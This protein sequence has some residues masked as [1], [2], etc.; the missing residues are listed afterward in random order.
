MAELPKL[1][2]M[3]EV[4]TMFGKSV[5]W[6]QIYMRENPHGRKV[7]K[8]RMFTDGDVQAMIDSMPRDP[9]PSRTPMRRPNKVA[10]TPPVTP[11]RG[12]AWAERLA[13]LPNHTPGGRSRKPK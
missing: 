12:T 4:A 1:H 11:N 10:L 5:R 13:K 9:P 3:A 6:L 7:G 8:T 2:T